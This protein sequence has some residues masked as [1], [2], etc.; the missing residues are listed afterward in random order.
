MNS[1]IPVV[2]VTD[3][4][5]DVDDVLALY[6]AIGSQKINLLGVIV[7]G[8]NNELR[9]HLA[10]RILTHMN[11][12][13]KI[14]VYGPEDNIGITSSHQF[15]MPKEFIYD[16]SRSYDDA[17]QFLIDTVRKNQGNICIA[18]IG[19]LT[20][21]ADAIQ[22]DPTF[23]QGVKSSSYK[24]KPLFTTQRMVLS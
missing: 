6:L 13:H 24:G 18:A 8:N 14:P 20:P 12:Q 15:T 17:T 23:T 9:A 10:R 16:V 19:P 22:T 4:G 21:L 5:G 2:L 11:L 1:N 3:I 7:T